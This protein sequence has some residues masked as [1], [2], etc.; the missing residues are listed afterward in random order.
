MS[1]QRLL[2]PLWHESLAKPLT[3]WV[4]GRRGHGRFLY[5]SARLA[6]IDGLFGNDLRNLWL[7]DIDFYIEK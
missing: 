7:R 1:R 3:S 4:S 6:A 5:G 2:C